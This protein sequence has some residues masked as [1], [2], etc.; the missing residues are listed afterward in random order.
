VLAEADMFFYTA[1]TVLKF[2]ALVRLRT[3]MADMPRP[4]S[5]PGGTV[6]VTAGAYTRY[7]FSST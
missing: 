2:S 1:S 3:S 5:I 7:D 6:G 4:F